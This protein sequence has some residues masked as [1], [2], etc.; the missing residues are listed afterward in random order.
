M[1]RYGWF[2]G[3][4]AYFIRSVMKKHCVE[5]VI[6]GFWK[7][8]E[9]YKNWLDLPFLV[10]VCV[11]V[12]V[13]VRCTVRNE[14][15]FEQCTTHTHIHQKKL[16]RAF[17]NV[18]RDNKYLYQENQRTYF[19]GIVHS[20]KKTGKVFFWQLEIFDVCITGDTAHIYTIL[21]FLPHTCQ[22]RHPVS[23]NCLYH[24]RMVLS[25]GGS[26]ACFARNTLCT[27]TTDLFVWYPNTQ[28]DFSPGAAIFSLHTLA[29]PSGRKV[30][31]DEKQ[32][33]GKKKSVSPSICIVFT[34]T[35]PTVFL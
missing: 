16:Y 35:C 10:Y 6:I 31:Y 15:N 34:N 11:C 25:V 1:H 29:S 27:V 3:V 32:R 22:H 8:N 23:V 18:L 20:H 7:Q 24:A 9:C 17:H 14:S 5:A 30:N 26:F 19:N 2:G 12:C 33:T 21:K 4:A 13:C 28:N